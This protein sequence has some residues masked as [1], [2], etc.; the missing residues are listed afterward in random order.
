MWDQLFSEY[1]RYRQPPYRC[2]QQSYGGQANE[3]QP[4]RIAPSSNLP[5]PLNY[6]SPEINASK[7][8]Q[9]KAS[10]RNHGIPNTNEFRYYRSCMDYSELYLR[11]CNHANNVQSTFQQL[12][13]DLPAIFTQ[14]LNNLRMRL[15]QV[16]KALP[17]SKIR[18]SIKRIPRHIEEVIGHDG[19][20][21]CREGAPNNKDYR[22]RWTE[23]E[24]QRSH[25]SMWATA[26]VGKAVEAVDDTDIE[27][28]D[29]SKRDN[30]V[31]MEL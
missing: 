30:D 27:N 23:K 10:N 11:C 9:I 21:G 18:R 28:V 14:P 24:R 8:Y 5:Y 25:Q 2:G 20:N 15:Q 1:P 22:A 12:S 4:H 3:G 29:D 7:T 26:R 19:G 31:A 16:W 17:Q 6:L 13:L